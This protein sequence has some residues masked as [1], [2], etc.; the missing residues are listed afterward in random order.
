[1]LGWLSFAVAYYGGSD[2][3]E[4]KLND[5]FSADDIPALRAA[6]QNG[7][8]QDWEKVIF[9]TTGKIRNSRLSVTGGNEKTKF[10]INGSIAD[11]TGIVKNTDFQR[12]SLRANIDHKLNDWIDIGVSSN[13]VQ[14]DNDR[15]WT[16]NDNSNTNYGYALPYTKPYINLMPDSQG[17]YPNDPNVG[18]NLLA[19]RDRAINNQK[20]TRFFQGVNANFRLINKEKTSL[21]VKFNGGLDYQNQFALI[22]LPSD[23]QSQI[24][25]ANPGFAQDTRGEVVNTNWQVSGVFTQS[26]MDNKLNLTT[27]AG[28]VRLNNR[29]RL[30]Y[31]RGRGLPAGVSNAGRAKVV[32]SDIEYRFNTD[33]GIFAQQEAN[34]DDK[35]IAAVGIRFDKSTLNGNSFDKFFAFPRASLAVNLAKFGEWGGNT[36]SQLKP[37]IAYG[38][39]AG[40]P[41]WGVPFSQLDSRFTMELP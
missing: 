5:Y 17:N 2:W 20:V 11:E 31:T 27:S 4:Q 3:T 1:M 18:E 7:T 12:Y 34:Y 33:V 25:E 36:V 13:F 35:I 38:A 6:K 23:L 39:T 8:Y 19:V 10:Y 29:T 37:R 15:G 22:W 26:L 24:K 40:V 41:N 30:L 32:A 21:T 16:G 28:L 14:S 9:G